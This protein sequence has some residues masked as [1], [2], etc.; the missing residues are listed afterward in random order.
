MFNDP[1]RRA[2]VDD[3]MARLA[4][5]GGAVRILDLRAWVEGNGLA[6]SQDARPDGVHWAPDTAYDLADR[7]LGPILLSIARTT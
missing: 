7:W 3:V 6:A 1:Q 4:D 5:P 2:V